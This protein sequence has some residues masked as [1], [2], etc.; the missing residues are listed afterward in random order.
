LRIDF[1]A[2]GGHVGW[3]AGPPWA[4]VYHMEGRVMHWYETAT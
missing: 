2:S 1:T 3:V 4:P